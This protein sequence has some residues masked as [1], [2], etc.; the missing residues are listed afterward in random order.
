MLTRIIIHPRVHSSHMMRACFVVLT[1][2]AWSGLGFGPE[3]SAFV[4]SVGS[5]FVGHTVPNASL[6][7][8]NLSPTAVDAEMK[9]WAA[10]HAFTSLTKGLDIAYRG[11]FFT[12]AVAQFCN[13]TGGSKPDWVFIDDERW[14]WDTWLGSVDSSSNAAAREKP[15]ET[16]QG[17]ARRMVSEVLGDYTAC[18]ASVSPRTTVGW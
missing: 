10:A 1:G 3:I 2:S 14:Q 11:V 6:L 5:D 9:V 18:L 8:P 12:Q 4:P 15:G 17:L 13:F 7:P 16:S